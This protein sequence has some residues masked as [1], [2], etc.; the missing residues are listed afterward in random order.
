M[1]EAAI[2]QRQRNC[3]S[4]RKILRFAQDDRKTMS[5]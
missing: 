3:S 1:I 2:H 4:Y 5:A